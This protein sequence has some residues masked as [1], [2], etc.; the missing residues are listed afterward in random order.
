MR[1]PLAAFV[2]LL[3]AAAS[4]WGQEH[5]VGNTKIVPP[6][7]PLLIEMLKGGGYI[8]FFRHGTTPDYQEPAVT[9]FADCPRQRNLNELGRAQAKSIGDAFTELGFKIGTVVASP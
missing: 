7:A 5:P 6:Q 9:D 2:L 8:V 1:A 3:I 4:A